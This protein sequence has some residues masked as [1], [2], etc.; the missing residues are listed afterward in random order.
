MLNL[1]TWQQL[2]KSGS[3]IV[4]VES[5]SASLPSVMEVFKQY[6]QS[7]SIPLYY[8]NC[9]HSSFK[10]VVKV[11][12]ETMQLDEIEEIN[13]NVSDR[14]L[15]V[16][17]GIIEA[18]AQDWESSSGIVIL[19]D[20]L[21]VVQ[22]HVHRVLEAQLVNLF[23]QLVSQE[24]QYVVILGDSIELSD[25]VR[26]LIPVIS[27]DLPGQAQINFIVSDFAEAQGWSDEEDFEF[28]VKACLGL[29]VG[30]IRLI[31][32]RSYL[33]CSGVIEK[34]SQYIA[35]YK[36][37][38]L[39]DQGLEF[40]SEPDVS[41][42]G[43]L[44]LLAVFLDDV[45]K[46]SKPSASQ[47]GLGMPKGMLLWG[48]PG[49]GKTL[50]AKLAAKKLGCP[51][52]ACSWGNLLG[53]KSPD[54]ALSKILRIVDSMGQC[55]LFFDDFDKGFAGWDS[56]AD[57]GVSRRLS[58]KLLTWMQEHTTPVM[59][60]A[61]ANR[62]EML[63]AELQRRFD[64]G[65]WFVDLP[66]MGA[67]HS[68]FNLHLAKYF[69]EQFGADRLSPWTEREWYTLLNDY[70]GATPA[71]IGNAVKRCATRAYCELSSQELADG[72]P[73]TVTVDDLRYER[74]QF[75]LSSIRSSEDIQAIRN[76]AHFARPAARPDRSPFATTKQTL[77]EYAP[78]ELDQQQVSQ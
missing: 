26:S 11:T 30:E 33:I 62:L 10:K 16:L 35:D 37:R 40:I 51:L 22:G 63:P 17:P 24:S 15:D 48:P 65:I 61:T 13:R 74:T 58:Q 38:H 23:Y 29:S 66:H 46:L 73:L 50:S 21:A 41:T 5:D 36:V 54:R 34:M 7:L 64:G 78:N 27:V 49:T 4:A 56:N 55:I 69:P 12:G 68:I 25:R 1:S 20:L 71:E 8:W 28:L 76:R 59:V 31:L 9:G 45:V 67:M 42:A 18:I 72:K 6:S 39:Q 47:Y 14:P 57:G 43:G 75:T 60:I 52:L 3:P 2:V 53:E 19:D 70:R 32:K 44:D 77:F